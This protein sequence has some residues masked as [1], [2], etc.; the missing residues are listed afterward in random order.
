MTFQSVFCSITSS[1]NFCVNICSFS[2]IT[3]LQTL[4]GDGN[5]SNYL[6]SATINRDPHFFGPGLYRDCMEVPYI[7]LHGDFLVHIYV[8]TCVLYIDIILRT[9]YYTILGQITLPLQNMSIYV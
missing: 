6:G 7:E 9:I 5:I 1:N 8:Y 3:V 4:D 2:D